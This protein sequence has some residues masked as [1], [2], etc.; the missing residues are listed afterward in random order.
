YT[1]SL[2]DAL[3]ICLQLTTERH[4]LVFQAEAEHLVAAIDPPR[5]EQ[6]LTNLLTNAI[7][8]SP[9]GG[10]IR[11]H[12]LACQQET[13]LQL[14]IQDQGIGIPLAQQA[15]IFGRFA[16]AENARLQGIGGTGLGLYLCRE[17]IEQHQGRIWFESSEGKGSTFFFTLPLFDEQQECEQE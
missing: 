1:L 14:S 13:H 10:V 6:V 7:K 12:L 11:V 2:H 5:I 4:R 17:L 15:Q 8:Y 9:E 16:R 3:P